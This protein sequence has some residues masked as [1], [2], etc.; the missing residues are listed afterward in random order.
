[1]IRIRKLTIINRLRWLD[2]YIDYQYDTRIPKH[3]QKS[4]ALVYAEYW[5]G[6]LEKVYE[7][8]KQSK[9][10]QRW[11]YRYLIDSDLNERLSG[12]YMDLLLRN[13]EI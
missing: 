4:A 13:Y 12:Y 8:V 1:M 5:M 2:K 6:T 3:H 10:N 11:F 9:D 7:F